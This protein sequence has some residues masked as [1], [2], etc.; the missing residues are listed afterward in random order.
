MITRQQV[1]DPKRRILIVCVQMFIEKGFK[2]TTMLDII[3]EADVSSGTFQNIFHTKDGVLQTL[4][5]FM[6]SNQ[7]GMARGVFE[8][9]PDPVAVYAA[10][11]A[12]Q[13]AITEL[14][15]NLR[16]IYVLCYTQPNLVEYIYWHTTRELYNI[17]G[18]YQ[19]ELSIEDFFI[20]EVGSA[21][22]M[23]SYMAK[24]CS[25]EM[26]LQRKLRS[27][28]TLSLR[29]YKVPEKEVMQ[30]VGYIERMNI[31]AI[32]EQIMQGLFQELTMHFTFS[33]SETAKQPVKNSHSSKAE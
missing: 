8:N 27:F 25:D 4:I 3:R 14:N 26:S 9:I 6:F 18:P 10:E 33:L 1:K 22:M 28:L 20:L 19:P 23:R 29:G 24:P 17:F 11:T 31:R 13:L 30:I 7:F 32:S 16:E 15:E 21:G 2:A 5:E 12:L